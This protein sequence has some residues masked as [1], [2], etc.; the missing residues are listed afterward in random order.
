M[1]Q[2][3]RVHLTCPSPRI[4][5]PAP[6]LCLVLEEAHSLV[7][8]WNSATNE[9]ER[10]SVNGTARAV[11]QG[12]RKYGYGCLLVTQRTAN[13]TKS[14][15][16]QCNTIFGMRVYDATGVGFLEN[17][18]GPTYARL[19]ASL[20]DRQAVI[21]GRASSCNSPLIADLNDSTD[22]LDD[23]WAEHRGSVPV[24]Q[25]PAGPGG[26]LAGE[27]EEDPFIPPADDDIPF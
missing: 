16:N 11:L 3:R 23:F 25:P 27:V 7:P 9:A 24:T 1:S 4:A 14:I 10:Q 19:L 8:E 15:L 22:F 12:R 2:L 17:Y 5:Q 21:F 26:A 13:V 18:I 20:R 6:A